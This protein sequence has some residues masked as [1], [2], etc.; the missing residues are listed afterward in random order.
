[1]KKIVAGAVLMVC[2]PFGGRAS[3]A[4]SWDSLNAKVIQMYQNQE[5]D[6]A[7]PLAQQALDEAE[8]DHGADSPQTVLAL[9]NLAML[10]KKTGKLKAAEPLYL[11]ALSISEKILPADHPDFAVPLNN[12]AMYYDSLKDY[13]KAD[14][15]SDRAIKVI[16]T[17]YGADHPQAEEAREKYAQ[18]KGGRA[19]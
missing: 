3:A 11:R 12:L 8:A 18:M 17:T 19:S 4:E 14:E 15:Y 1:M 13:A 9:N 5:Y 10:Y 6:G 16:E 2:F 7:I